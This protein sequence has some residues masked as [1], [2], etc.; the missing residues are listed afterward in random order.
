M[1][2]RRVLVLCSLLK[3]NGLDVYLDFLVR[4]GRGGGVY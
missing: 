1:L 4:G 3:L 2:R